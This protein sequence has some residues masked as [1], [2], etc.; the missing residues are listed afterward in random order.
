MK[1]INVPSVIVG[2]FVA[3]LVFNIGD[4]I[5]NVVLLA[6]DNAEMAVRLGLDPTIMEKPAGILPFVAI[7]FLF[8]WLAV[9][10]YAAIRPRFGPGPKTALIAGLIPFLATVFLMIGFTSI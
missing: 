10:T 7:D 8:G 5:I 1:P 2:G 4:F 6:A 9:F 3:G